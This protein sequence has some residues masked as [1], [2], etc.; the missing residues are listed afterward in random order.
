MRTLLSVI[1][2][3]SFLA[4]AHAA[5]VMT[6]VNKAIVAIE[7]EE[8]GRLGG[9]RQAV[10]SKKE[11]FQ[12]QSFDVDNFNASLVARG[13]PDWVWNVMRHRGNNTGDADMCA[14]LGRTYKVPPLKKVP[15][16]DELK[17]W[18]ADTWPKQP[19]VV[20]KANQTA[21]KQLNFASGRDLQDI[22]SEPIMIPV[23]DGF[24]KYKWKKTLS[25][26]VNNIG[27][28]IIEQDGDSHALPDQLV[29]KGG[30]EKDYDSE[31]ACTRA[32]SGI[33]GFPQLFGDAFKFRDT[34]YKALI[35]E[36][37]SGTM[38]GD[39]MPLDVQSE[40]ELQESAGRLMCGL[41]DRDYVEM[42]WNNPG[43]WIRRSTAQGEE[44]T[45]IDLG[46][47]W[48]SQASFDLKYKGFQAYQTMLTNLTSDNHDMMWHSGFFEWFIG[49]K[50]DAKHLGV[51]DLVLNSQK[52]VR[53]L[54]VSFPGN[55]VSKIGGA[56]WAPTD[57]LCKAH[58]VDTQG[59]NFELSVA[60]LQPG[61]YEFK[62]SVNAETEGF[63]T[64]TFGQ[65]GV[66]DDPNGGRSGIVFTLGQ[67][68]SVT[69]KFDLRTKHASA[70]IESHPKRSI[71]HDL[72][73]HA[74][75]ADERAPIIHDLPMHAVDTD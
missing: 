47:C 31:V 1:A 57:P 24:A 59:R 70:V 43:N 40:C 61:S 54:T 63:W 68:E 44:W 51:G 53:D 26:G 73:M 32:G 15:D 19:P 14:G 49:R 27:L 30:T 20:K 35:L 71:I 36:V 29:L 3:S 6:D 48:N 56:D 12:Q 13:F 67:N 39:A 66:L 46:M 16:R 58:K 72:P 45:R 52:R 38:W 62:A 41:A 21:C 8:R 25:G 65:D 60:G 50:G 7:R 55:Y 33:K 22:Q 17:A 74:V 64:Q 11:A 42:D 28:H 69:L 18:C 5:R 37:V 2:W 34:C 23:N 75:D 9:S 4:L 10:S